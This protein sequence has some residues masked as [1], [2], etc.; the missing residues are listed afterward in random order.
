VTRAIVASSVTFG[1]FSDE[2][3]DLLRAAGY[4]VRFVDRDDRPG[5][6]AAL[7]DAEAWIAGF[8]PVDASTLSGAPHVRVVAKCGVGLDTFD[9]DHLRSRGIRW[10]NVPGGNSGAV[11]EYAIGQLLALA[12]GVSTNDALVRDGGWRPVV[13]RGLDGRTL[14]IVG[15]GAIGTRVGALARAFG[16]QIVVTDPVLDERALA[17]VDGRARPLPELLAV[18]DAV[19][20]HVPLAPD[21]R[22]LIGAAELA[23]MRPEAFLV[24]AARG[25]VVDETALVDALRSGTIAGAALDVTEHEPLP[26]DSPLRGAPNLLLS[27]HTAGYSDTALAVVTRTCAESLLAAL[28]DQ[29]EAIR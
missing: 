25:G 2:P 17:A 23:A 29:K 10:V 14:G 1:R 12:R 21:T 15:Y 6:L 28:A 8:E 24:N 3:V 19:T 27:P 18:A 26:A 16:L 7:A 5:L 11:A 9:L 22:H 13:G 20:L 4:E